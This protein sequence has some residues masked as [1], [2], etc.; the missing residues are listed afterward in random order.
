V[1]NLNRRISLTLRPQSRCTFTMNVASV[2]A[3]SKG[4]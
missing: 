3:T 4:I 2:S 1:F